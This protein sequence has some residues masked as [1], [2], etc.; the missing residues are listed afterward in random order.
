MLPGTDVAS[1]FVAGERMRLTME[2]TVLDALQPPQP[3]TVS[4]GVAGYTKRNGDIEALIRRADEALYRAKAAGRNT[5]VA[6]D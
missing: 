1:A 4:I 2:S 3:V 5:V 6:A